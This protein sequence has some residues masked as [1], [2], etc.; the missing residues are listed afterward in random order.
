MTTGPHFRESLL[1][2]KERVAEG[3]EKIRAQHGKG[4]PGVQVCARLTDLIDSVVLDLYHDAL[5]ALGERDLHRHVALVPHGG[6]GRRHLAPYSDLDLMILHSGKCEAAVARLA[7]RLMQDLYDLG[8]TP[9]HSVRTPAEAVLLGRDDPTI[10][11]SLFEARFLAGNEDLF[12]D[13]LARQRKMVQRRY[14]TLHEAIVVARRQERAQYGETVYLLSPNLKRSRGGLREIQLLRWI[15]FAKFGT[16]DPDGLQLR[17]ALAQHDAHLLRSAT[18]FLLRLRNEMH[19]HAGRAH[20]TLDRHEQVRLAEVFGYRGSSGLLPVEYF[21]REYFRH[22]SQVRN[23]VS[24]FVKSVRPTAVSQM[25]GPVFSHLVEGD[26][27]VGLQHIAATR[28]GLAKLQFDLEEVL[29][30][31]DLANLYDKHIDHATWD[32]VARAAPGYSSDVTPRVAARFLSLMAQPPQLA[33]LL[34]RLHELH[35]LEKILPAFEHAR[36]LLQFNEYHKYTVDEHSFRAVQAATD[37]A[38]DEGPLGQAYRGIRQKRTLHLALLIHDLG[39]GF[40]RDHSEVGRTIAEET[41]RR[42]ELPRSEAE[43]LKFLVH[44]HLR[45]AHLAFRRDTSDD[46]LVLKVAVEVGTPEMLRMLYVLTCADLAAVGPGVLNAWKVEL[47]TVLYRR[48]MRHLTGDAN[49]ADP[50]AAVARGRVREYLQREAGGQWYAE[51]LDAL[52]SS[53]LQGRSPKAVAETLRRLSKLR[54]GQA[55][56]WAKYQRETQ[57]VEVTVLLSP[58]LEREAFCHLTGAL[59]SQGLAILSADINTLPDGLV[60]DRFVVRDCDY[61]GPPPEERLSRVGAAVVEAVLQRK[62]PK[63]RKLWGG[64]EGAK[65]SQLSPLETVVKIDNSTSEAYTILDIFT[66]DRRGLLYAVARTLVDLQLSISVA[67]IGTYLDQVVDVFYVTDQT[68]RKVQDEQRLA[69]IREK[70][71]RAIEE[72]PG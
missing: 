18:E 11:T 1:A 31:T 39:K 60:L 8:L 45:M 44:K 12:R 19:F 57:T 70:L 62:P 69:E 25:L 48:A 36:C 66:F 7:A 40:D 20:D 22:T 61:A 37:F 17:G 41:A 65:L 33:Q 27:R 9:G 4:S 71:L 50:N 26:Y 58:E 29:R 16:S 24:R 30:L 46:E 34:R 67:K 35:V 23:L 54:A 52:P 56:A 43:V 49:E 59:T 10:A 28:Q 42:L 72:L 68:G 6:Y 3:R 38:Q 2:A 14:R 53:Y 32:A 5:E 51:H 64:D 13:F 55:G 63:F 15:G 47:L 21:M